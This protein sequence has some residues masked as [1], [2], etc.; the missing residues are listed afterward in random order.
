MK[1]RLERAASNSRGSLARFASAPGR[2]SFAVRGLLLLAILALFAGW[3]GA[4]ASIRL[5]SLKARLI[6]SPT[7]GVAGQPMTL[8]VEFQAAREVSWRDLSIQASGWSVDRWTGLPATTLAAGGTTRA[9]LTATPGE[10]FGPLVLTAEV[11]G[12]PWK[13]SFDLSREAYGGLL[14][15]DSAEPP[16]VRLL[17]ATSR[18]FPEAGELPMA[19][20]EACLAADQA[21][22][23]ATPGKPADPGKIERTPITV[24][25]GISY[26]HYE[27]GHEVPAYAATVKIFYRI[28]GVPLFFSS[29]PVETAPDGT[30]SAEIP[31]G[32]SYFVKFEAKN[33]VVCV[34]DA[35]YE[36]DW[37]WSTGT[38]PIPEGVTQLDA[39]WFSPNTHYGALNIVADISYAHDLSESEGYDAGLTDV[40]WPDDDENTS[41]YVP[42]WEE[43]H[44]QTGDAWA[45][46]TICHEW[47]HHWNNE[48]A[49]QLDPSYCNGICD[50]GLNCSHCVWCPENDPTSWV[51]GVAQILSRI[52]TDHIEASVW[53]PVDH[54]GIHD[55]P[56]GGYGSI[57]PDCPWLPWDI[58]GVWAAAAWDMIDPD[59]FTEHDLP[60]ADPLGRPLYDKMSIPAGDVLRL[61]AEPC[62]AEGH[63]PYR[64]RG[65]FRCALEYCED[66][67]SPELQKTRLWETVMNCGLDLDEEIPGVATN[68]ECTLPIG[69]PTPLSL[70]RITWDEAPDDLSGVCGYSVR[71]SPDYPQMPD[72]SPDV[73][74]TDY[75]SEQLA[76]GTWY[77]SVRA[78]DRSGRWSD[79]YAS[80]GPV[81]I[82]APSPADLVP[83][84]PGGWSSALV[85]RS[86]TV[87]SS[88]PV[89]QTSFVQGDNVYLNYAGE[90]T[91]GPTGNFFD[92]GYLDGEIVY[93][94]LPRYYGGEY[95]YEER[96]QGPFDLGATGRHTMWMRLD[97]SNTVPEIL[98]NNN[99]H[100]KQ[101]VFT[102]ALLLPDE[103]VAV[104][105]TP[106]PV[107]GLS[108]LPSGT[109]AYP[110]CDGYR[111]PA[112]T[113]PE[114][115][116][117][118]SET[119]G[120]HHWMKLHPY[121]IDQ[122]GF[123]TPLS[124]T[125]T[126][127][128]R[129]AV[130]VHD[131]Q[132][133]G[134]LS[135]C[136]GIE[137]GQA[138]SGPYRICREAGQMLALPDTQI[139]VIAADDPLDFYSA[140][141][142]LG[143]DG[144]FT[145][146]L[147]NI[148]SQELR[149]SWFAPG[150][151]QGSLEDADTTLV[152]SPG[153]SLI[154][155][156]SLPAGELT[157]FVVSRDP[158]AAPGG[159]YDLAIY[160][161][162]PDLEAHKPWNWDFN[163]IPQ[164]GTPY[165]PEGTIYGPGS[166]IG[167]VDTTGVYY[168]LR[169]NSPAG[170]PVGV[171]FDV[172]V[173]G[174]FLFGGVFIEPLPPGYELKNVHS[175]LHMVRGG[176]HTLSHRLNRLQSI[177][178]DDYRN[179][180]AGRQWVW[181]PLEI[182]ASQVSVQPAPPNPQGG[183]GWITDGEVAVNCDGFHTSSMNPQSQNI[184]A[185]YVA[186]DALDVNV[187]LYVDAH[188]VNGFTE[189]HAISETSGAGCDFVLRWLGQHET[190]QHYLGVS[191]GVNPSTGDYVLSTQVSLESWADPVGHNLRSD[192]ASGAY[193]DVIRLNLPPG[194]YQFTLDSDDVELGFSLHDLTEA[195]GSKSSPFG[196]GLAIQ[197]P[198]TVG[199][200]VAFTVD[201]PD[202]APAR[203]ALA[204]WRPDGT[205]G[206][207]RADW[208][209]TV[210]EDLALPVVEA[211]AIAASRL[212]GA[213]PNPFHPKT[214]VAFELAR[215]G[216]VDLEVHDVGGRL[217][218]TLVGQTLTAGR[219]HVVW[220][221]QD[222]D[223][224]AVPA[225]VYVARLR[226]AGHPVDR[227]KL[228]LLR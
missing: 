64:P 80:I 221:G 144:W 218:R 29:A 165:E 45:D 102:P 164:V 4:E 180:F 47:G 177:D 124:T 213:A 174:S 225:G 121:T 163:V 16:P 44:L 154:L 194:R 13:K 136:V 120:S 215:E 196:Q 114:L 116:W 201:V 175:N 37:V 15:S 20:F 212:A 75:D 157:L 82:L 133:S 22:P 183:W 171:R 204:V 184:F 100:A 17:P 103:T 130:I 48:F 172:E 86:S 1:P 23:P 41:Y 105:T 83:D 198:G 146:R 170:A 119:E 81:I 208:K 118:V 158:R 226:L 77:L 107:A 216:R 166:L 181:S 168:A 207:T 110:N 69:V 74:D 31:G 199:Q 142:H 160:H 185:A 191:R 85:V 127:A 152:A 200:D 14:P 18:S 3:N 149:L 57:D 173:D 141:N 38:F 148:T 197:P 145:I 203:F 210:S 26:F 167:G 90:N 70:A 169:N 104:S 122:S 21:N 117:A 132:H 189:A 126:Y 186:D 206:A 33:G 58:E 59:M 6:G 55:I 182:G 87:P 12:R 123:T 143:E 34:E 178:E 66:L 134:I 112:C 39:G 228:T 52:M 217:V 97:G 8:T 93:T 60:I 89:T 161:Q 62:D 193:L 223:G 92:H 5:D 88:G 179:N 113:A 202:P 10:A 187:G 108:L 131:P 192:L 71:I 50:D 209:V 227:M 56:N 140:Y 137:G 11:D 24:T 147:W 138:D 99:I 32:E 115:V 73:S 54:A 129:P 176:R 150:F 205:T 94:S 42:Y 211:P 25:G 222:A 111:V 156:T 95:Q 28:P 79:A 109:P 84:T 2:H 98:E 76:P 135:Y 162:K 51:E 72:T 36:D 155:H 219:H 214:T 19:A 91:G 53:F 101:F 195:Y 139:V 35:Y 125:R 78:V 46:A 220:D 67:P 65:F 40:Q 30:F 96:N 151:A 68:L 27:L 43:I 7:F 153:D 224:R 9:T 49:H 128:D 188:V 63:E 106:D 190:G 159:R 61:L